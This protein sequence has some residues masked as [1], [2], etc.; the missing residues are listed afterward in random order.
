MRAHQ[1]RALFLLTSLLSLSL[2][3]CFGG[4]GGG[5]GGKGGGGNG[6]GGGGNL[7]PVF[8]ITKTHTGNFQQGQQNAT[9]TITITNVGTAPTSGNVQVTDTPPPGET[10]VS[11]SGSGWSFPGGP[12]ATRSD[13]LPVGQ[14]WPP[15]T[16]TVNVAANATSPQVNM[17]SV[18]GG[19][20]QAANAQDSTTITSPSVSVLSGHYAFLFNGFDAHGA[21]SVAGSF[22]V[23]ANGNLS[24][25]EDFKDP[26]TLVTAQSVAG[27]CRNSAFANTGFCRLTVA[28]QTYQY[29][30]VLRSVAPVAR[31]FEDPA[32]NT[33]VTGSGLLIAQQVPS[34]DALTSAGGFNGFFSLGLVGTNAA[35]GRMGVEGNIFTNLS[36]TI[37]TQNGLPSQADVN[38]NGTLIAPVDS[39]TPNVTGSMTGP[40]DANGRATAQMTIGT[41]PSQRTLTLAFYILAPQVPITNQSGR[42]FAVDITPP[43]ANK[44]VL[45]GQLFWEGSAPPY[46]ASSIS[47][48][49]VFALSG[50]VPGSPAASNI[51]M[52]I[53]NA[54]TNQMLLDANNGGTVNGGGGVGSPLAGTVSNISVAS[55]GRALLSITVGNKPFTFVLYFDAPDDGNILETGGDNTVSV[56]FFTGQA[57]TSRFN[58]AHIFG[59]Y[60][61]GTDAPLLPSVP[62]VA[63]QITL[64]PGA[65]ANSGTFSDATGTVTG[66]YSFDPATGRGTAL[67]SSGMLFQNSNV[68]FYIITPNVIELMGADQNVKNDALSFMQF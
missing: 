46:S 42:A 27:F 14:S 32:D 45:S 61:F 41:L 11:G 28:G 59:T 4:H 40:V 66:S 13:P 16:V 48:A 53:L 50:I 34:S 62:N 8:Q 24:G 3:A 15:I 47:G 43:L 6:G 55:N 33:G 31:F 36:A 49:N 51:V 39:V 2:V 68:V 65:G 12:V 54:T 35:G 60:A 63:G 52:G 7:F 20:G 37:A 29:D 56:G 67:A 30:F 25:E 64:T 18:S 38:D 58:N 19:G 5:G 26:A 1:S 21:V 10:L 9:Y 57:P 22:N 23:D 17:V 44:Q